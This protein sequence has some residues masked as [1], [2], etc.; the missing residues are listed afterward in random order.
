M[1]E[2]K[3]DDQTVI[4]HI[5]DV[6]ALYQGV[7]RDHAKSGLEIE[8][9][10]FDPASPNLDAM[11]L[12]QNR[13]LKHSAMEALPDVDWVHN[14]P[15]SELLEVA[16]S[17]VAFGSIG[18]VITEANHKVEILSERAE[19][20]GLKR[21]YF[22]ELPDKTADDLL[23]RIVEVDRY[24]I[25]YAPYREDMYDC[26]RYFAV[27]KSNQVSVSPYSAD[28]MLENVRRLYALAPFLFLLT[29]N[30][31]GFSEGEPFS[32]HIGMEL[33]HQ[34]LQQGRGGVPSYVFEA[35]SGDE[36]IEAHVNHV[37]NNPLFMYYDLDGGLQRVPSGDWSVTFN[38]LR[39]RGLNTTSNYNLGQSVLWPD[40]KIAALKDAAG[41]T[42]SHRYEARMFGVG[43]HQHQS[44]YIITSALAFDEGFARGVDSLLD[45]YG[46]NSGSGVQGYALVMKSY[47][48]ARDH[49]GQFMDIEYG[50]GRM[51]DFAR[52]FADLVEEMADANNLTEEVNPILSICRTGCTDGKINRL[53]F[54]TLED[55]IQFQ[56]EYDPEIF[57]NSNNSARSYFEEA[58]P[59][60]GRFATSSCS[61]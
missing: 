27:C 32:G 52:E 31:T 39:S 29:D 42:F 12:A 50:Q 25:M 45:S 60:Y 41:T 58:A 2:V 30:S 22:Q 33:R 53:M 57:N 35:K 6:R 46:F 43:I 37:M 13:V 11:S 51:I 4:N 10:F 47:Q 9:S 7:G 8:L 20:I 17:A 15:T 19:G 44:A 3:A 49:N 38:S 28:H 48:A 34:G 5:D 24:Q 40:I 18:E 26:V 56:A 16:T 23:S 61:R 1:S 54:P 21:S 14:E 55:V 36:Y 59:K